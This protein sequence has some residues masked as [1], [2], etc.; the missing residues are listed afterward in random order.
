MELI[1]N[2]ENIF[3]Y[4]KVY[5]IEP[6]IWEID[7]IHNQRRKYFVKTIEGP[8]LSTKRGDTLRSI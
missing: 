7:G 5:C 1:I 6:E 8:N 4:L 2:G 3:V